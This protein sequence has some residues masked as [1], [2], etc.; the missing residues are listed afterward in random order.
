MISNNILLS[1]A[2]SKVPIL[3]AVANR[4]VVLA[5]IPLDETGGTPSDPT[6]NLEQF[7]NNRG[8]AGEGGALHGI[9][10]MVHNYGGGIFNIG[11]DIILYCIGFGCLSVAGGLLLHS[12]NPNKRGEIKEGAG[13]KLIGA[14]IGLGSIGLISLIAGVATNFFS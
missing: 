10:D 13:W 8:A 9:S 14:I 11:Q 4:I 2:A 12:N 6:N 3:N 1:V 5:T 7:F